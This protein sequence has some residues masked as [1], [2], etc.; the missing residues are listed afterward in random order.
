VAYGIAVK[1]PAGIVT[2]LGNRLERELEDGIIGLPRYIKRW[3][4]KPTGNRYRK[5]TARK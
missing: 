4:E 5:M 1:L 2:F 3:V